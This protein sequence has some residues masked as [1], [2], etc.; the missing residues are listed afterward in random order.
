MFRSIAKVLWSQTT[1]ERR[2]M[3]TGNR[4]RER[5]SVH[6][7]IHVVWTAVITLAMAGIHCATGHLWPDTLERTGNGWK[8]GQ[9][10]GHLG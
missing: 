8:S 3:K 6:K 7:G 9:V 5:E 1:V 4:E 10:E 2:S